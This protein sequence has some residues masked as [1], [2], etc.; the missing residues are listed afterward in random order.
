MCKHIFIYP[1]DIP[2]NYNPDGLTLTGRCRCG[3]VQ[4]SYGLRW[5][6]REYDKLSEETPYGETLDRQILT[7]YSR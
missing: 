6:L 4:K 2:E 7:C 5:A 3:A 1:E